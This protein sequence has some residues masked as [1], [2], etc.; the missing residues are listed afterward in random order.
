MRTQYI[1]KLTNG[2]LFQDGP[3]ARWTQEE[4]DATRFNFMTIAL[5]KAIELGYR[6]DEFV[7][8]AV[9]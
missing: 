5:A 4:K 6:L 7:V 9:A 8:I 3:N 1:I 2:S